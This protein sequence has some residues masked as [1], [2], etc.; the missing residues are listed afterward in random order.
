MQKKKKLWSSVRLLH[1]RNLG[2]EVDAY[3]YHF[4]WKAHVLLLLF[5]LAGIGA[6]G[7]LFQLSPVL[8]VVLAAAVACA[9]PIL[10]LDMYKRMYEQKRFADVA[11]YMEQMLY[12]FQKTGKVISAWKECLESFSEGQMRQTLE[13]AIRHLEA[14]KPETEQGVLRESFDIIEVQY[15]CQKLHIVHELLAGMEDYGGEAENSILLL[16]EDIANWK[17]RGYR[18]QAE[19][20]K[21]HTDNMISIICAVV[22]CAVAL[23]VLDQMK[24]MFAAESSLIVFQIPVIQVSSTVFLIILLYVFVKSVRNLTDD[25]LTEDA[26]WE[27]GYLVK[28]Y[29]M[30]RNY[31][32]KKERRKSLICAAPVAVL[33]CIL[34]LLGKSGWSLLLV[35]PLV[36]L[37]LQHRIG[38]HIAKKDVTNAMYLSLPQW[39]MEMAL[40]LQNNNVQVSL[41][42][43]MEDAPELLK[44][45]LGALME[46]LKENPGKL[47]A[48]TSFCSSFDLP[49]VSSCM[50]MLHAV[51][52]N[53][54]GNIR[55]QMQHL[56]E[57]VN[58]MQGRADDIANEGIAF[59]MKLIFSYPVVA[60]TAK[61]LIDLTVGMIVMLQFLGGMG[62]H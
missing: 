42:K 29:D 38:Y 28:S 10:I 33:L 11:A 13:R 9:V 12:S 16:L 62:G 2:R 57:R 4:S 54:T 14:G 5:T 31:D 48:Y 19:K 41:M 51:C 8:F 61:L 39:L 17:K 53:G 27:Q 20:K 50:K 37:I 21:S 3:G 36:F 60:A 30:I 43:S 32:E 45:E 46:R 34:L 6:V 49:E 23:Y 15:G 24:H 40:L 56:L 1:P 44:K 25:W 18:L 59:R 26:I 47:Q 7:F 55:V 35:I 58:E 52:E 22:L